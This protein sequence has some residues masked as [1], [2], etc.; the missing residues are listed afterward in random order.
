MF[1]TCSSSTT[2]FM[3]A[4]SH[5]LDMPNF[6]CYG[7][8]IQTDC[9][10]VYALADMYDIQDLK[11][12]SISKFEQAA[13]RDWKSSSFPQVIDYV[14]KSTPTSDRGLRDIIVKT[15]V[16]H[17]ELVSDGKFD[18]LLEAHGQVG[19]DILK[20]VLAAKADPTG[21]YDCDLCDETVTMKLSPY[22]MTYCI[23]CLEIRPNTDWV[24]LKVESP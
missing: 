19:K 24:K 3:L 21:H 7:N 23:N 5:F 22:G 4:M 20:G 17:S 14:Y 18:Q 16:K 11:T 10:Q 8:T 1:A 9:E 15:I 6:N 13:Q 12:L 2:D